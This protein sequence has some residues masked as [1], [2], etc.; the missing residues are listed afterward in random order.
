MLKMTDGTGVELG[1]T[2]LIRP[3]EYVKAI[4]TNTI[5]KEGDL[6]KLKIMAYE[7]ETYNS[8]GSVSL[9]TSMSKDL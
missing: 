5:P 7:P 8:L 6:V 2:G 4:T 9:N 3:N 1:Q